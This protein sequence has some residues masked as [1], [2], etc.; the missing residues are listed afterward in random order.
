[1][2]R[3]LHGKRHAQHLARRRAGGGQKPSPYHLWVEIEHH[4]NGKRI[5]PTAVSRHTASKFYSPV[6]FALRT[7]PLRRGEEQHE[8]ITDNLFEPKKKDGCFE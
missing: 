5:C 4:R 1:L 8:N 7:H 3:H 6:V 2:P